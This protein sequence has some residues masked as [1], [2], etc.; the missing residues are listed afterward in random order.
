LGTLIIMGA[1][2]ASL[3]LV[4]VTSALEATL[5]ALKAVGA[6]PMYRVGGMAI[7][8][9]RDRPDR[10][11]PLFDHMAAQ[12]FDAD[13]LHRAMTARGLSMERRRWVTD[14]LAHSSPRSG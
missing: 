14:R 7:E 1:G 6:D 3:R 5:T 8:L 13:L 4:S 11:E 2:E 9:L 10:Y 12:G